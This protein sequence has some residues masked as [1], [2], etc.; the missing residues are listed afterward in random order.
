MLVRLGSSSKG[1]GVKIKKYEQKT[2]QRCLAFISIVSGAA[3]AMRTNLLVT[4]VSCGRKALST[5]GA[6]LG[7]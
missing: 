7:L 5:L 3:I 4:V 6:V 1:P 2:T